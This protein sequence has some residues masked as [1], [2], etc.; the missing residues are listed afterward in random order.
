MI[1]EL[2]N[3]SFSEG[4]DGAILVSQLVTSIRQQ[5]TKK[6]QLL[7]LLDS[8]IDV[9]KSPDPHLKLLSVLGQFAY[10]K[11]TTKTVA[12]S[13]QPL[14]VS[15]SIVELEKQALK[16]KPSESLLKKQ[17]AKKLNT[18]TST[19]TNKST[20]NWDKLIEY[21]KNNH[22]ALYCVLSKCSYE[23]NDDNLTLYTNGK[24]YKKKLDDSRY[25]SLLSKCLQETG[26]FGLNIHT[27]PTNI[28]PKDSKL[29]AVTAIMGGGVEV[30]L[31][32]S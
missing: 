29:A 13:V 30:S 31:E 14:E 17:I 22:I 10:Q 20:F 28:P 23:L 12:L 11:P 5:I 3:R 21:T 19:I 16:D 25:T 1:V 15:S 2:L 9:A 18:K 32:A 26:A 24:F 8:L 27:V 4:I 7:S 6:P